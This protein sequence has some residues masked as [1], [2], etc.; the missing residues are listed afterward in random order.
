MK[1]NSLFALLDGLTTGRLGIWIKYLSAYMG[2]VFTFICGY[3]V[4]NGYPMEA[5]HNTPIQL[6]FFGGLTSMLAMVV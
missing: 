6:L 4:L 2:S 3:G 1:D 5:I